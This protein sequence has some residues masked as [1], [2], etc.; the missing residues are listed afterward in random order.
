L[1]TW[2]QNLQL[3]PHVHVIVPGGGLSADG[4]RW[5]ACRPGF[6]L[7]VKVLS[8][9]FRGKLLDYLKTEY[10]GGRL[11]WRGELAYLAD[12]QDF[13]RFLSLLYRAEWVV[14]A[15]PPFG[16]AEQVLKYLA[17]Y[18]YRVAISNERIESI[19]NGQVIFR[20]KDYA[21]GSIWRPMTLPA[22]EFLRRFLLHVLPKG[23]VRIRTFGLLA[24]RRR[25]E[26][27]ARCR[28][29]LGASAPETPP[30]PSGEPPADEPLRCPHC[31]QGVLELAYEVA[32]PRV[33]ELVARTYD[34]RYF[35]SS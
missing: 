28:E 30:A 21:R 19:D 3:H 8:R 2:G 33:L 11:Q 16:G 9:L 13:R 15:K 23:L 32:R 31:G 4:N 24:N 7:P 29:L 20:Y 12:P 6:F 25:A 27:L 1:H 26:N 5:V 10:D 14:Y 18:T 17:R 35:D 22:H 34:P